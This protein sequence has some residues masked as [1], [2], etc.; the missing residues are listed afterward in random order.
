M[1]DG[2]HFYRFARRTE[3]RGESRGWSYVGAMISTRFAMRYSSVNRRVLTWMGMGPGR[4]GIWVGPETVRV[5]MGWGF[6]AEFPR[7][8]VHHIGPGTG[9]VLN[10]LGGV[11]G[12]AGRWI[13]SGA[14]DGLVRLDLASEARA[15]VM[16][17]PMRLTSLQ[18]SVETAPELLRALGPAAA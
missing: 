6:R 16:G 9:T 8:D 5:A 1:P 18:V 14:S 2:D 10:S 7:R 4:S 3:S 12:W 15:R 17:I 11:R 13:L